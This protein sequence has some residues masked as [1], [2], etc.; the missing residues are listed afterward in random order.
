MPKGTGPSSFV[1][2]DLLEMAVDFFTDS[3]YMA[4]EFAPVGP[5][6]SLNS[7]IEVSNPKIG[8]FKIEFEVEYDEWVTEKG[9][10][11]VIVKW[12]YADGQKVDKRAAGQHS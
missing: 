12:R 9:L 8:H 11:D 6:E 3:K 7:F 10:Y 1:H 2:S 4:L 5:E